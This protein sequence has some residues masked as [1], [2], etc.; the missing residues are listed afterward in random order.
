MLKFNHESVHDLQHLVK[1]VTKCKTE[2]MRFDLEY[3]LV[4]IISSESAHASTTDVL[5]EHA[6]P[7][8][9]SPDLLPLL[10]EE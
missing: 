3:D 8:I 4:I 10:H 7:S 9:A 5:A 1:L 2:Y 6:I